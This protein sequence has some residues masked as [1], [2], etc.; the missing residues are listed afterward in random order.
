[1]KRVEINLIEGSSVTGKVVSTPWL[2]SDEAA[3]YCGI[4]ETG[5]LKR[6]QNLPH[7]G[8]EEMILYHTSVLDAFIEGKIPE[9]PFKKTS[10]LK[11]LEK[12]VK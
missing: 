8:N 2:R 6:A 12:T 9:A 10:G 4:S 3:V 7:S 5:F 11:S 1:M